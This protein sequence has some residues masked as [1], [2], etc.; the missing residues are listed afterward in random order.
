AFHPVHRDGPAGAERRCFTPDEVDVADA[1]ELLVVGHAGLTIAEADFRPQKEIDVNPAIGRLALI[2]P[3]L[4]PLVDGERPGGFGKDRPVERR[5]AKRIRRRRCGE[6]DR[7]AANPGDQHGGGDSHDPLAHGRSSGCCWP[8]R[9]FLQPKTHT[10]PPATKGST[11]A[12]LVN[13]DKV[14]LVSQIPARAY[15][16]LGFGSGGYTGTAGTKPLRFGISTCGS[17]L[18]SMTSSSLMMPFR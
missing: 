7:V 12:Q 16:Q 2:S 8:R 14:I 11:M 15:H 1:I 5:H 3:P 9:T 10:P 18:A 4:S 6:E 13:E 17:V